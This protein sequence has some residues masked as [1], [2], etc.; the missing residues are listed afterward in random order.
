MVKLNSST[1]TVGI[2]LNSQHLV[3][4]GDNVIFRWFF[5]DFTL[6]LLLSIRFTHLPNHQSNSYLILE[7][8]YYS[9]KARGLQGEYAQ[10]FL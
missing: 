1:M 8:K 4:E 3:K 10:I 5:R 7:S 2:L 6:K 9:F